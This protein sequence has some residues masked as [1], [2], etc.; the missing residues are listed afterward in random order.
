MVFLYNDIHV[1]LLTYP[2]SNIEECSRLDPENVQAL[3]YVYCMAESIL[4]RKLEE[5]EKDQK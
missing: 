3:K 1:F 4:L 5:Y 2:I